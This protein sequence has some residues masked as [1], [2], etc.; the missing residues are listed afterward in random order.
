MRRGARF[1]CIALAMGF[2]RERGGAHRLCCPQGPLRFL[3][4]AEQ[5]SRPCSLPRVGALLG[6]AKPAA[7]PASA[8]EIRG[9]YDT[10]FQCLSDAPAPAGQE[11]AG[12]MCMWDADA[13]RVGAL[14]CQLALYLKTN[15]TRGTEL[16]DALPAGKKGADLV[17][18]LDTIAGMAPPRKT[19][20][21][22]CSLRK[23]QRTK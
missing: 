19:R 3:A 20:S 11:S 2:G 8:L 15:R 10:Y 7:E 22:R 1:G 5:R 23:G 16:L 9:N 13:D 6:S 14:V 18:D 17:W 4:F 12:L 21:P